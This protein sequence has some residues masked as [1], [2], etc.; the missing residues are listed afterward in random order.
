MPKKKICWLDIH[1][2]GRTGVAR[3]I[4]LSL[5]FSVRNVVPGP[6]CDAVDTL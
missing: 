1:S 5:K 4:V 2:D 6:P 3:F